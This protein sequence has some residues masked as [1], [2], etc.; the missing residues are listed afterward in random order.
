MSGSNKQPAKNEENFSKMKEKMQRLFG[1]GKSS[2]PLNVPKAATREVVFTPEILKEIGPE[3]PANNRIRTIRELCEIVKYRHLENNAVEALWGQIS[4]LL[5]PHVSLENRQL[6]LHF[7]HCLLQGQLPNMTIVRGH[8]FRVIQNLTEPADIHHRLEL[9]Q[10]LSECGK[11]LLYFEDETG[12]FLL[13]WMPDIMS[14]G[15][16]TTFLPIILNV[17]KYNAAYLD[18]EIMSGLVQQTCMIPN[19]TR[20]DDEITKCLQVLDAVICYSY[21]PSD[22]LYHFVAALCHTVDKAP[23]SEKSWELMKKLLGTYLGHSAIFTMCCMLQD[24]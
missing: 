7:L 21:L 14:A 3:S 17:I 4:D 15:Y 8:F 10:T 20:S 22:S 16:T 23:Y 2:A 13:K 1:F 11:N 18:E 12:Q 9:F 6:A 5:Q 24:K 19:R